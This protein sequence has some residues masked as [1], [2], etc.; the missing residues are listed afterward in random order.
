METSNLL[1]K[2]S[3]SNLKLEV[4]GSHSPLVTWNMMAVAKYTNIIYRIRRDRLIKC[5]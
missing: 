3:N 2:T 4:D 1:L 5:A